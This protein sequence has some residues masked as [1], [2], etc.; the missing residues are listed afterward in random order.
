M[1]A[2]TKSIY[3]NAKK[4]KYRRNCRLLTVNDKKELKTKI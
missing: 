2:K 4:E 1:E 3:K